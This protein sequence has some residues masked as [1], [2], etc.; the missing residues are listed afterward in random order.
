MA[1]NIIRQ[2]QPYV[3]GGAIKQSLIS[4]RASHIFS[5][6]MKDQGSGSRINL[7]VESSVQLDDGNGKQNAIDAVI[8]ISME[9]KRMV[10]MGILDVK[11]MWI[12]IFRCVGLICR[13]GG[14]LGWAGTVIGLVVHN[15]HSI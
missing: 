1:Q 15:G 2:D 6:F 5:Q 8:S 11:L 9:H 4:M 12:Q 3:G 13:M 14:I 7:S 10:S